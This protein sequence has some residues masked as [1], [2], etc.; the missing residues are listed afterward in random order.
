M[1][2]TLCATPSA[3]CS[4]RILFYT[5]FKPLGHS[6]PSGDLVTATGIFD[7]LLKQGHQVVPVSNLRCRW[8]YWKPWLWP[9]LLRERRRI[10][11]KFNE[12]PAFINRKRRHK[13]YLFNG[14][15]DS[16]QFL[17]PSISKNAGIWLLCNWNSE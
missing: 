11:K 6:H 10:V 9:K 15:G 8:I 16:C 4:L 3:P 5:P 7:F 1:S 13:H 12:S 2:N 17:S 14:S